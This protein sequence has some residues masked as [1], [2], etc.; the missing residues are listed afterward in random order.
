MWR[1]VTGEQQLV[2]LLSREHSNFAFV[3]GRGD[4]GDKSDKVDPIDSSDHR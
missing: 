4:I 1:N 3:H 2:N